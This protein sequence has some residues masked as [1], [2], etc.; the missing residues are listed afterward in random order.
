M[1]VNPLLPDEQIVESSTEQEKELYGRY[2]RTRDEYDKL[3]GLTL[4]DGVPSTIAFVDKAWPDPEVCDCYE[5]WEE[6]WCLRERDRMRRVMSQSE[7]ID[8]I[9]ATNFGSASSRA[10]HLWTMEML[11]TPFCLIG[12][13][14]FGGV[15][16]GY[17]MDPG[18]AYLWPNFEDDQDSDLL[19]RNILAINTNVRIEGEFTKGQGSALPATQTSPQKR[20]REAESSGGETVRSADSEDADCPGGFLFVQLGAVFAYGGSTKPWTELRTSERN[21]VSR[22]PWTATGFGV[23][24]QIDSRGRQGPVWVIYNSHTIDENDTSDK[25][26]HYHVPIMAEDSST[27][28]PH[29]GRLTAACDRTFTIAKIAD[30]LAE[31]ENKSARIDFRVEAMVEFQMVRVKAC[32]SSPGMPLVRQFVKAA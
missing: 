32:S 16:T 6:A 23:L 11:N 20:R 5:E 21:D 3:C 30:S 4:V 24:L 19:H 1:P 15:L 27:P 18:P 9:S 28:L 8:T 10:Q 22:G 17:A 25:Q 14:D 29:I 31:L 2:I 7:F 12:E 13:S 26:R